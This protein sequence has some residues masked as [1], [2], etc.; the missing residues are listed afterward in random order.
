MPV[1]YVYHVCF[2]EYMFLRTNASGARFD[3]LSNLIT[4]IGLVTTFQRINL[5]ATPVLRYPVGIRIAPARPRPRATATAIR[6]WST[7]ILYRIL[8]L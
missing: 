4:G 3:T 1:T 6:P 5:F 7:R 8:L 2:E